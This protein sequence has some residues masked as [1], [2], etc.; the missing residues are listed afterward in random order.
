[1]KIHDD[2][3]ETLCAM[4]VNWTKMS[5]WLY[6]S[7]YLTGDGTCH[8]QLQFIMMSDGDETCNFRWKENHRLCELSQ[9]DMKETVAHEIAVPF[10]QIKVIYRTTFHFCSKNRNH[11]LLFQCHT[12]FLELFCIWSSKKKFR[13]ITVYICLFTSFFVL[14]LSI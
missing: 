10:V 2:G 3:D 13:K 11:I 5:L 9:D 8:N 1:M 7:E 6:S 12:W 4:T 14:R